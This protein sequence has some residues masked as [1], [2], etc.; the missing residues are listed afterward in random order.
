MVKID[1]AF[2]KT[3]LF[4][5]AEN[6]ERLSR[7][8]RFNTRLANIFEK[9]TMLALFSVRT[10]IERSKVSQELL[11]ETIEVMAYPKKAP[12]PVTWLNS[13]DIDEL[14]NVNAPKAKQLT[15]SFL[16]NQV[17]HSYILIPLHEDRKFTH[18]LVCSDHERNRWLYVVPVERIT[19][20]IRDVAFDYASRTDITF[21]PK[22][23][24][25]DIRNYR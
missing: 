23:R 17:I 2:W 20:L 19:K 22:R 15:P 1:S 13:H 4:P 21:N 12:K 25:Y 6:I 9:E 3:E 14:Y 11:S 18:I 8:S 10:L 7:F 5:V 24:D 16:C